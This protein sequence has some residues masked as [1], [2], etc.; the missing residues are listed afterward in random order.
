MEGVPSIA[1]PFL[2]Q[3]CSPGRPTDYDPGALW[4]GVWLRTQVRGDSHVF[5]RSPEGWPINKL[6]HTISRL[7]WDVAPGLAKLSW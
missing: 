7:G 2:D 1:P 5:S 6:H 3:S 4:E